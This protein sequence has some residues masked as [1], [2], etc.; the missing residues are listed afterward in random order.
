MTNQS[1]DV[2]PEAL[3]HGIHILRDRFPGIVDGFQH[4]HRNRFDIGEEFRH[5]LGGAGPQGSER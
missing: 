5:P 3:I 4:I 1:A 2:N